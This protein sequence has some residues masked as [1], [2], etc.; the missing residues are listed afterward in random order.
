MSGQGIA[1]IVFYAAVLVALAYP[2]GLY[3][4]RVYTS[5]RF[6][7]GRGF[8]WLRAT[9]RGFYRV[10]RT[11]AGKEQDW[12]GYA[13]TVLV[14]SILFAGLVYAI[15]RLQ[16]HDARVL[17]APQLLRILERLSR[18]RRLRVNLPVGD[19]VRAASGGQV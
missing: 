18:E 13:K 5:E 2:L 7:S 9:E 6:L 14:F 10:V 1:Q 11:D 8:G 4:A 12:K 3:M 16:A 15:Q 19:A 17:H